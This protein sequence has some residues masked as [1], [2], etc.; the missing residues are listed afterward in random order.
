MTIFPH[1][2]NSAGR[3][4]KKMHGIRLLP[5]RFFAAF[6]A[7]LIFFC[8]HV[9]LPASVPGEL[10]VSAG[11]S[12]IT[13]LGDMISDARDA[14]ES[15]EPFHFSEYLEYTQDRLSGSA[16]LTFLYSPA[17]LFGVSA[18]YQSVLPSPVFTGSVL[19]KGFTGFSAGAYTQTSIPGLIDLFS[20]SRTD[21]HEDNNSSQI[22]NIHQQ[23]LDYGLLLFGSM[24]YNQYLHTKTR[25]FSVDAGAAP[26]AE[27]TFLL[28]NADA[29]NDA[30][31]DDSSGLWVKQHR[32]QVRM[33]VTYHF[34]R[35]IEHAVSVGLAA[36]WVIPISYNTGGNARNGL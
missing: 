8:A 3:A 19:Y 29:R 6:A 26:Y 17:V 10:R 21:Q 7:V 15:G 25:F 36:A 35:D 23:S 30:R 11:Y 34:R 24:H 32:L 1:D 5:I 4:E 9:Q 2:E 14:E 31:N 18:G 20:G 16:E 27:F 22:L 28:L 12:G 33:P 13:A